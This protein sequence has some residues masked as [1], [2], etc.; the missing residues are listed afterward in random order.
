M[1]R[2]TH[3]T[4]LM[5]FFIACCI[6]YGD[7]SSADE[8]EAVA[9]RVQAY[10][11]AFNRRDIDACAEHW[12]ESAEYVLPASGSR[13]RGR[14]AIRKAL[15]K[16]LGTDERFKLSVSDQRFRQVSR[17]V[18]LEEGSARVVSAR[19]GIEQADYVVVHV[20]NVSLL[21]G[22]RVSPSRNRAAAAHSLAAQ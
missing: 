11:T 7:E 12:S 16:L 3:P 14:K 1:I 13:V 2:L 8:T 4:C 15:Q 9:A 5:H 17:D 18:V 19:H 6:A 21:S 22:G 10:V 20:D